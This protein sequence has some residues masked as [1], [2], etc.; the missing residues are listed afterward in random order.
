MS[1]RGGPSSYA[2][3]ITQAQELVRKGRLADPDE[4]FPYK[5]DD[6]ERA[7]LPGAIAAACET[8]VAAQKAYLE[9]P[10]DGT[11]S[12]YEA[13]KEALVQARREQRIAEGRPGSE[14][15]AQV[16]TDNEEG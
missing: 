4:H 5:R 9:D 14:T 8:Y 10:G 7:G 11:R 1:N 13:A 3:A 16:T 6:A 12:E 2:D 15:F